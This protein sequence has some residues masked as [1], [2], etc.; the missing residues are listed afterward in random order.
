MINL[1][2][3]SLIFKLLRISVV[4]ITLG[5]NFTKKYIRSIVLY[6]QLVYK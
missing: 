2:S 3:E 4:K 5:Y 1:N 6:V